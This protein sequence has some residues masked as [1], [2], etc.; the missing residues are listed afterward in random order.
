MP[1]PVVGTL[2]FEVSSPKAKAPRSRCQPYCF[3][4]RGSD[5]HGVPGQRIAGVARVSHVLGFG[6]GLEH[7]QAGRLVGARRNAIGRERVGAAI[8]RA[9][10][11]AAVGRARVA[12][13]GLEILDVGVVEIGRAPLRFD[14]AAEIGAIGRI[15][16]RGVGVR[17]RG[18]VLDLQRIERR[19][20]I[21][22]DLDRRVA[23]GG[24]I[25]GVLLR[26]LVAAIAIVGEIFVDQ[27][28]ADAGVG[29][30]LG[31]TDE[32]V[33]IGGARIGSL[34]DQRNAGHAAAATTAA[35]A[36]QG[37]A[38]EHHEFTHLGVPLKNSGP[39]YA[40]RVKIDLKRWPARRAFSPAARQ[41]SR[42]YRC[43]A[44]PG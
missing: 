31:G 30:G 29:L 15:L 43:P 2:A 21:V 38:S 18:G 7:E 39:D 40:N 19:A 5:R 25:A 3:D 11:A 27:A 16:E 24:G 10:S 8:D 41:S 12:V 1:V 23:D 44:S 13:A 4:R 6:A 42:T 17:A 36:E 32:R 9:R 14:R 33:R 34:G 35:G 22:A 37:R 28:S 20:G 26:L